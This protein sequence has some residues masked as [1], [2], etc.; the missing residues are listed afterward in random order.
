MTADSVTAWLDAAG[1]YPLL[2]REETTSLAL[3]VQTGPIQTAAPAAEKLYCHNLRLVPHVWKRQYGYITGGD[4][5]I[6]DLLQEGAIGLKT[7]VER[8]D[9]FRASFST[10]AVQWIRQGMNSYL[11]SRDRTIRIS[12]DCYGVYAKVRKLRA[13]HFAA[14]G[15]ELTLCELAKAVGR[16][17]ESVAEYLAMMRE[18]NSV[19]ADAPVTGEEGGSTLIDHICAPEHSPAEDLA[20]GQRQQR[21]SDELSE[22]LDMAELTEEQLVVLKERFLVGQPM[23]YDAIARAHG[24]GNGKRAQTLCSNALRRCRSAA[25]HLSRSA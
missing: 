10:F 15:Q 24:L 9:P 4:A 25:R 12:S 7:A 1:R 22:V 2:T 8:Y 13:A 14:T 11:R 5:R 17:Q 6:P 16:K 21:F 23:S 18:T 19:S 3:E 20:Y